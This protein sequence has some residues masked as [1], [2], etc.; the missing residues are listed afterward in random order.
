MS[1]ANTELVPGE[2]V[3]V[4]ELLPHVT[5]DVCRKCNTGWMKR[6]EDAAKHLVTPWTRRSAGRFTLTVTRRGCL[7]CGRLSTWMA[8]ALSQAK[9]AG[10]FFDVERRAMVAETGTVDRSRV[11]LMHSDA[12]TAYVGMGLLPTLITPDGEVPDLAAAP[13]NAEFGHLAYNG[14]VLFAAVAPAADSPM[15]D[16]IEE[17]VNDVGFAKR[18]R[19]PSSDEYFPSQC[20]PSASMSELLGIAGKLERAVGLPFVRLS[21]SDLQEVQAAYAAGADAFQVRAKWQPD[22]LAQIER[23]RIENDP[24]GYGKTWQPYMTLGGIEWHGGRHEAA[25]EHYQQGAG[26]W[27][28][29]A[30]DRIATLR[31]LDARGRVRGSRGSFEGVDG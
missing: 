30:G 18:I 16:L 22:D 5:V 15:L 17:A 31:H 3:R 21:E 6:L 23:W 28:D 2:V 10:P 19:P 14:L 29:D 25:L 8:Y 24:D 1:M 27:R 9:D 11:W 13:D 12:P 4:A 26:E 20:A 7:P